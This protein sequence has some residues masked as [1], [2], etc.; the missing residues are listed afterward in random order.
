MFLN[1]LRYE[2]PYF[3]CFISLVSISIT[4]SF[5]FSLGYTPYSSISTNPNSLI[6]PLPVIITFPSSLS[7]ISCKFVPSYTQYTY[8]LT[9]LCLTLLAIIKPASSE[10]LYPISASLFLRMYIYLAYYHSP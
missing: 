7:A 1:F 2:N 9:S 10:Q 3:K 6:F 8:V 4:S 5:I